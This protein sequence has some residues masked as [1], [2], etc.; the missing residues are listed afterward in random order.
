MNRVHLTQDMDQKIPPVNTLTNVIQ[1]KESGWFP[2]TSCC[3]TSTMRQN[4]P[5][6]RFHSLV[7]DSKHMFLTTAFCRKQGALSRSRLYF[8]SGL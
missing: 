4:A 8:Y 5:S 6:F 3:N 7:T 1:L 2:T